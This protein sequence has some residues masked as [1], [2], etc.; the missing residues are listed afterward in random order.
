MTQLQHKGLISI[1]GLIGVGKT[2]LADGLA[3]ILN[4]SVVYEPYKDNPFLA[5]QF[6]GCP[7]AALPSELFFLLNRANQL[8]VENYHNN[9]LYI[10]DYIFQNNRIFATLSLDDRQLAIYDEVEAAVLPVINQPDLVIYLYDS[11]E[12]CRSRIISRG[13][14]FESSISCHFLAR[15][16]EKY[17]ELFNNWHICPLLKINCQGLD[18]RT[19][20]AL[21]HISDLISQ[22]PPFTPHI[23]Q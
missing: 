19:K 12:N 14:D 3:G 20:E 10:T 16:S 2:T 17:E 11:P 22:I 18:F 9:S 7:E 13:R 1:A 5:R 21:A 4:A 15:L 23:K 6:S 8:A